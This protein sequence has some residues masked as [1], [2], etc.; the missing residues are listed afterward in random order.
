MGKKKYHPVLLGRL[1]VLGNV[2]YLLFV[3]VFV[4]IF[5]KHGVRVE[6]QIMLVYRVVSEEEALPAYRPG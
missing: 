4:T 1:P 3:I 5:R 2:W 6:F